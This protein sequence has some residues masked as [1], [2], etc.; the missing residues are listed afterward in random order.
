MNSHPRHISPQQHSAL[1]QLLASVRLWSGVP[2]VAVCSARTIYK[3]RPVKT[4]MT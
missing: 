4:A 1:Q 2:A 3:M